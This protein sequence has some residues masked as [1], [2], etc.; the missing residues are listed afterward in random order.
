MKRLIGR[1]MASLGEMLGW[2]RALLLVQNEGGAIAWWMVPAG[3]PLMV[4]VN[5]DDSLSITLG[6]FD[7]GDALLVELE[8]LLE[9]RSAKQG[10]RTGAQAADGGGRDR[11]CVDGL[12]CCRGCGWKSAGVVSG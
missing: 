12:G 10:T 7:P 11:D 9:S 4:Q 6:H 2:Q 8:T 5:T 3:E 1:L